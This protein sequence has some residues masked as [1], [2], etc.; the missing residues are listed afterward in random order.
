MHQLLPC[1]FCGCTDIKMWNG[2]G[3]QA[4]LYCN[5]CGCNRGVQVSDLLS[6]EERYK[7]ENSFN[8]KTLR[9]PQ[10]VVEKAIQH[11]VKEWNTRK[12]PS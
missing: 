3:T 1:P 2:K 5:E 7:D 12:C 9:F 11:L 8:M 10:H 6:H 4:E